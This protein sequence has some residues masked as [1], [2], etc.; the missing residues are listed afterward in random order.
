MLGNLCTLPTISRIGASCRI[1]HGQPTT[2][3]EQGWTERTA[4]QDVL[5]EIANQ[6]VV[7]RIHGNYSDTICNN[8]SR[9]FGGGSI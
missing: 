9:T 5:H 1:S 4:R 2:E 3:T 6:A 8:D 7:Q